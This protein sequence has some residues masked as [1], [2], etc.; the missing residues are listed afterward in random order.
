MQRQ[1]E[2]LVV[3]VRVRQFAERLL[4]GAHLVI[5]IQ[6]VSDQPVAMGAD[7]HRA[8]ATEEHRARDSDDIGRRHA[9][10]DQKEGLRSC[11]RARRE[12][13]GSVEIYVVDLVAGHEGLN[14]ERL[15]GFRNGLG[16]L[17]GLKR[18][19]I[20]GPD[21]VPFDLV[22]RLDALV[23]FGIDVLAVHA[24]SGLAVQDMKRDALGRRRGR[25]ERDRAC[26][27]VDFEDALPVRARRHG[28]FRLH[29][30]ACSTAA[31]VR[32]FHM[33]KGSRQTGGG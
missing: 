9:V 18:D 16:D 27:L 10:T 11:R 2:H 6:R 7:Q 32:M 20:A 13:I 28:P 14:V 4:G 8:H 1:V 17:L 24:M 3:G 31:D 23:G 26:H 19:V 25:E 33:A 29:Q 5:E 15:V 22:L 12:V 21:F 30:D